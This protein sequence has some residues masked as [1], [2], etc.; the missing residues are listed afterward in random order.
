MSSFLTKT[1]TGLL[2]AALL[3][4]AALAFNDLGISNA[5]PWIVLLAVLLMAPLLFRR[6]RQCQGFVIWQP[7]FE[8]G[9]ESIDADHK[10]LLSLINNLMAAV[11]CN[12]GEIFE[13]QVLREIADYAQYHFQ[14]EEELMQ[15]FGYFD[16][17]GHKAQHDQM[18]DQ[19]EVFLR[20]YDKDGR[21]SLKAVGEYLER[22][23]LQHINGT[24]KKYVPLLREHGVR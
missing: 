22:W 9:I 1:L 4:A 8:V 12:T 14:R 7:E 21:K 16:F 24:D 11:Y 10:K 3:I 19:I 5:V 17:D 20:R 13:R 18:A 23:L 15:R 2:L 6:Q